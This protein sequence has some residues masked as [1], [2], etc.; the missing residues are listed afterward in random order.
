MNKNIIKQLDSFEK[1]IDKTHNELNKTINEFK[2][3]L[4]IIRKE[5]KNNK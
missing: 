2:L 4:K 3:L 5:T 1:Q